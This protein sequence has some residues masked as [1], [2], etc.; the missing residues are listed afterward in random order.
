[1]STPCGQAGSM[2]AGKS[3]STTECISEK[4]EHAGWITDAPLF[5]RI[6]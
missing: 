1:M 4:I 2:E 5:C 6:C 3:L